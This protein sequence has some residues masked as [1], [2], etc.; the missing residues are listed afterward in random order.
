MRRWPLLRQARS[1]MDDSRDMYMESGSM[2]MEVASKQRQSTKRRPA[3]KLEIALPE[4]GRSMEQDREWFVVHVDDEWQRIRFHEYEKIFAVPGLYEKVIYDALQ[5]QSPEVVTDLLVQAMTTAGH[6]PGQLRVLDL[7]AGNGMVGE[8]L[9]RRGADL[10]VGVDI[11]EEAAGAARRD[12]PDVYDDYH[13]VDLAHLTEG[14]RH[15]LLA[16]R[17]NCMV[18]VAALGFGDIPIEVFTAAFN[19]VRDDG[20]IAFNIKEDFLTSQDPSGFARLIRAMT[21]DGALEVSCRRRYQHRLGTDRNPIY[22]VGIVGR[23]RR[24][25][26][27]QQ[28]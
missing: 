8:L 9:A 26:T 3:R 20:W 17:I 19:L 24:D 15:E 11:I 25:I 12:R 28:N 5:C 13:V 10:M 18:C 4:P 23:K 6:A 7:G 27:C 22:Y 1:A 21:E 14:Q 2:P 16:H